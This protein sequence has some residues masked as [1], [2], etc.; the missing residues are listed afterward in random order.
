MGISKFPEIL[1]KLSMCKQYVPASFPRPHIS[2]ETRLFSSGYFLLLYFIIYFI[3]F[4]S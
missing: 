3:L 1:G 2:L 4:Y